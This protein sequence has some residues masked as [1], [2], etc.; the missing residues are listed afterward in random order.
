M[1]TIEVGHSPD[2]DDAFMFYGLASG[3]VAT[4][5]FAW[6][7]VLADIETLNRW[8]FEGRLPV[9]A[10]SFA[11][12]AKVAARYVLLPYGASIGEGYGPIV[13]AGSPKRPADLHGTTIAIPGEH[14]TA[15]LVARLA[16]PSFVPNVVPF[17]RILDTVVSGAAD[18]GVIIHEAQLTYKHRRLHKVV[19]L[20]EWWAET[21]GLPLPLGA[22]AVRDD[23]PPALKRVVA[24]G[25]MRSILYAFDHRY[26]A[27]E[28]ALK[29]ARGVDEATAD[30]FVDMYVNRRCIEMGDDARK[31]IETLFQK[32][33]ERG[34]LPSLVVPRYV[35]G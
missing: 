3:K 33:S 25:L 16:L 35:E 29:F 26:E 32:G 5:G 8:A 1:Q 10:L 11:A 34:L 12:Y 9:T 2:A 14:T 6:K 17:D 21:T 19:D 7:H 24:D 23:L 20:G 4:P 27:L 31:A 30:R 28:H 18:A 13:V 15:A 22:N